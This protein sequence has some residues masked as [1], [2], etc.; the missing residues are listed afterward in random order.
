MY[1]LAV[2]SVALFAGQ[3]AATAISARSPILSLIRR[4]SASEFDPSDIPPQCQSQ[5][6]TISTALTSDS[7]TSDLSCLCSSSTSNG[8]YNCLE[9]ALSLDPDESIMA[10]AQSEFDQYAQACTSAGATVEDKTLTIPSGS[11]ATGS[12]GSA[13]GGVTPTATSPSDSGSKST[14]AQQTDGAQETGSDSDPLK[15]INK[16]GAGVTTA[17]S[18]VGLAG[19][20]GAMMLALTL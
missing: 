1:G 12:E 8:L 13:T 15:S 7:C 18:S 20:V 9:C 3:A 5:C 10:E 16:T 19:A 17:V 4:Q 11:S 2:L 14:A 6:S